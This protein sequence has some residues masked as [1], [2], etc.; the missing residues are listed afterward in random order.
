MKRLGYFSVTSASNS[1]EW[2]SKSC[3]I[4]YITEPKIIMCCGEKLNAFYLNS[5]IDALFPFFICIH[6]SACKLSDVPSCSVDDSY[7][8]SQVL[9][10]SCL[11]VETLKSP[12]QKDKHRSPKYTFEC[13]SPQVDVGTDAL[14][15]LMKYRLPS[16]W[17]AGVPRSRAALAGP[18]GPRGSAGPC[19]R[20]LPAPA[21]R[22]D[23]ESHMWS[24][25]K[26]DA[27]FPFVKSSCW[28]VVSF[29]MYERKLIRSTCTDSMSFSFYFFFKTYLTT[30]PYYCWL[31]WCQK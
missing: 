12:H 23:S 25:R 17:G 27:V 4:T 29:A 15:M 20:G 1:S 16:A 31:E 30:F 9:E 24:C 2:T 7:T 26:T 21:P 8:F 19:S 10:Q 13:F 28:K 14:H 11:A 6:H 5:S 22:S 3:W 18:R